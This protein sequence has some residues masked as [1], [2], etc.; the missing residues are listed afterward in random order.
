MRSFVM[1]VACGLSP[2]LAFSAVYE[3]VSPLIPVWSDDVHNYGP[4][5][6]GAAACLSASPSIYYL[7]GVKIEYVSLDGFGSGVCKF[8]VKWTN[9]ST[10]LLIQQGS[11]DYKWMT[12]GYACSSGFT[13]VPSRGACIKS[14]VSL[15][16]TPAKRSSCSDV[17][18]NP[19]TIGDGAK[20]Q[21]EE[22]AYIFRRGRRIGLNRQYHAGNAS[23]CDV[24]LGTG[25]TLSSWGARLQILGDIATPSAMLVRAHRPD[26]QLID[27]T[28]DAVS[29]SWFSSPDGLELS[30][31][32]GGWTL[33]DRNRGRIEN[34]FEE[35]TLSGYTT[36]EGSVVQL[37]YQPRL[38]LG[39]CADT[40]QSLI[41]VL[42][43]GDLAWTLNPADDGRI[44]SVQAPDLQVDATYDYGVDVH[45][46]RRVY[47]S[48]GS[49]KEYLREPANNQNLILNGAGSSPQGGLQVVSWTRN[50]TIKPVAQ[51][52]E[53]WALYQA[54]FGRFDPF[55]FTGILD[56]NG[57]RF[58][59]YVY[60]STG[61]VIHDDHA[62]TYNFDFSYGSNTTTITTPDKANLT[63]NFSTVNGWLRPTSRTQPSGS[64]C[65]AATRSMAY[66]A[67]GNLISEVD[68]NG[69]RV[70]R[71][72]DAARG[73]E[74]AHIDGYL[75]ADTC[76]AS[77]QNA[78]MPAD[79]TKRKTTKQWHPD[80]NLETRRAESLKI[81]T[82][83]YNGQPDPTAGN[84]VAS[85]APATALLPDGK[86][87]VVLCKQVEQATT[88]INGKL[89]LSAVGG[90][91]RT[92]SYTYNQYGQVLNATDP[93]GGTTVYVYAPI[94]TGDYTA[95]DLESVT[96]PAGHTTQYTR[97]D[98]HGRPLQI[99]APDGLTTD[100]SY[101]P[102]GWL[103]TT[104][105]T[106]AGA[107]TGRTTSY[108]YDLVG[109]LKTVSF[110]DATTLSYKYDAA[111]RLYN[112][113][114]N[115]GNSVTYTLDD[116]GHR[117]REA[118]TDPTGV[119]VKNMTRVYDALGRAQSVTGAR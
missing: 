56:E 71:D 7:S 75:S 49:F 43:D 64:G 81:T 30:H 48:D 51:Q 105:V 62:G 52:L 47:R 44:L 91:S 13:Y 88:D 100:L 1:A 42:I 24:Q 84:A 90:V 12:E 89:G 106:P 117:T 67:A 108:T 40:T 102:R 114:D 18:S 34:Y 3:Q 72:V 2:V 104:T 111:H 22:D 119:L 37:G 33:K 112:I 5:T 6:S 57:D 94:T 4:F 103:K 41:R 118:F 46:L 14:I 60:D 98:A 78:V 115:L 113:Q 107:A 69:N 20:V 83:V 9:A 59:T 79:I 10:G 61:R 68:F 109:Q 116:A 29:G 39:S 28:Y 63:V 45:L 50:I 96:N 38:N 99:I 25:W 53:P 16:T 97:Y 21:D 95:G 8:T 58:A 15:E 76:P 19:V 32:S 11:F 77:V 35:G 93:R 17:I 110:P 54:Q 82:W 23:L 55:A 85:C 73:L 27:L 74:T 26:G 70:C 36:A 92:W 80:W 66:D 86:P 31:N 87:I 65:N 101:Y